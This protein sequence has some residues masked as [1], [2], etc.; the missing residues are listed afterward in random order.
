MQLYK[1]K[2][3]SRFTVHFNEL[4]TENLRTIINDISIKNIELCYYLE[5]IIAKEYGRFYGKRIM[6]MNIYSDTFHIVV[7]ILIQNENIAFAKPKCK[8]NTLNVTRIKFNDEKEFL[9]WNDRHKY[10]YTV[11]AR[12]NDFLEVLIYQVSKED[13]I[14]LA[15]QNIKI[16][17][18]INIFAYIIFSIIDI[19][20]KRIVCNAST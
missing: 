16:E 18:S 7:D 12:R 5:K 13:E 3:E 14:N 6:I 4:E 1:T 9:K 2:F 11:K 17:Q 8:K 15:F 20:K 19:L 10:K